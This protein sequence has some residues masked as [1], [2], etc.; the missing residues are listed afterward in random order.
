[1]R[2]FLFLPALLL[3]TGCCQFSGEDFAID[4]VYDVLFADYAV[5]DT[6]WFEESGG[7]LDTAI[8]TKL[9]FY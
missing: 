5:G 6:L 8:V 2:L 7:D 3:L 9:E 1:M 4:E